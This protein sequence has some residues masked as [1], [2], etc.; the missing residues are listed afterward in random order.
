M[1]CEN[2]RKFTQNDEVK[3][4]EDRSREREGLTVRKCESISHSGS[5]SA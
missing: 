2:G 5:K 1:V 3:I 4:E